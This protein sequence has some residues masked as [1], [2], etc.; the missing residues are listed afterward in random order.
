MGSQWKKE[1]DDKGEAHHKRKTSDCPY[2]QRQKK[3]H[4]FE[5]PEKSRELEVTWAHSV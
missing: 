2:T 5:V 3:E 1:Q 4:A